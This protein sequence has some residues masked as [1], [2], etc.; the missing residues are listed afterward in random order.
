MQFGSEDQRQPNQ[1][2]YAQHL[3][4][5]AAFQDYWPSKPS[6]KDPMASLTSSANQSPNSCN[7]T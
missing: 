3:I 4:Q 5:A 1:H 2:I 6:E 7:F